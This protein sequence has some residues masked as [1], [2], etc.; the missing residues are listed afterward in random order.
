MEGSDM[1]D[2]LMRLMIA[3]TGVMLVFVSGCSPSP[4][5]YLESNTSYTAAN[6][7]D[8]LEEVDTAAIA[9]RSAADSGELRQRALVALRGEGDG[10]AQA[11]DLITETFPA[12]TR[13]VPVYVERA[14][15]DGQAALLMVE[16][17]GPPS[18]QLMDARLWVFDESGSILFSDLRQSP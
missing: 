17:T 5:I 8:L 2:R 12:D 4:V 16:A 11:A 9:K 18:G 6:S 13:G 14:S 7:S 10:G 15:Y 1:V 3:A